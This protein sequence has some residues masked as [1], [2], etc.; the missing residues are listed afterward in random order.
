KFVNIWMWKSKRHADSEP[1]YQD[2]EKMYPNLG[3][4]SYPNFLRSPVEQP[5][6]HA[7]TLDSDPVY[8]TGWGAG[9]IV[10]DPTR[11]EAVEDLRAQ[12]F[13]TLSAR[14]PID[15]TVKAV[16]VYEANTYRVVFRRA[17]KV[18]GKEAVSLRPGE[19]V[20]V[21][22]AVWNGSAGDRD[23]KKSI[24]IWQDLEIER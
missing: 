21:A 5:A 15:R 2:L 17:L 13:G 16:G 23:G 18:K 10:S 8:V 9:N 3:I 24:T 20:P 19:S 1:A 4:D 22:F 14:P 7:L 11:R 6:R 12:G